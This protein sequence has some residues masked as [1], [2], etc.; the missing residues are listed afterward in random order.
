MTEQLYSVLERETLGG[1]SFVLLGG[2][3]EA[4]VSAAAAAV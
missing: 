2:I 3:C 1:S 4:C